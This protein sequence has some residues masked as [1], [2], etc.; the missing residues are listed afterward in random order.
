MKISSPSYWSD[1][2]QRGQAFSLDLFFKITGAKTVTSLNANSVLTAFDA[3]AAQS[4]IDNFLG[5]TNEFVI[6]QFDATAM[7]TDAFACIVAMGGQASALLAVTAATYSGTNG[8]T[9]LPAGINSSA[10]LTAS[11]HTSE[12]ALGANGDMAARLV[13]TGVDALTSGLIKV[14]FYYRSK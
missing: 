7:G 5:T 11:S 2:V 13:L 10:A 8:L 12:C 14:T 9:V 3:I 6:A 4:T 1:A